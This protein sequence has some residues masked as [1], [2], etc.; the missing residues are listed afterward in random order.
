MGTF[1]SPPL[2]HNGLVFCT[3]FA[4]KKS[5]HGYGNTLTDLVTRKTL[6]KQNTYTFTT[7]AHGLGYFN[8]GAGGRFTTANSGTLGI[9]LGTELSVGIWYRKTTSRSIWRN[10]SNI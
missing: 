3:D 1:Y 5:Y 4:N 2:I 6:T 8:G 7:T 10:C 9:T